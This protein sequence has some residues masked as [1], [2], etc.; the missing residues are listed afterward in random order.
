[1]KNSG[2]THTPD[3]LPRKI[4]LKSM[5]PYALNIAAKATVSIYWLTRLIFL[6]FRM[7]AA[8]GRFFDSLALAFVRGLAQLCFGALA[9]AV[10]F[11]VL[12]ALI[13][14]IFHPWF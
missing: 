10:F 6:P 14:T 2:V 12:F 3:N 13:R 1:M 11:A 5:Q 7:L 8:A 9:M 4:T